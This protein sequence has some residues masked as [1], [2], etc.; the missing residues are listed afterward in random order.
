MYLSEVALAA[1]LAMNCAFVLISFCV[2]YGSTGV[3]WERAWV[4]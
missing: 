4:I 3:V 1:K 2:Y